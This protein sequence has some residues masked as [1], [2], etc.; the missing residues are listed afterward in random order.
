MIGILPVALR[1]SA[2]LTHLFMQLQLS[3]EPD[4]IEMRLDISVLSAKQQG[5]DP[6]IIV[7]DLGK[8]AATKAIL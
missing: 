1:F 8:L 2:G 6:K 7:L 3:C 5:V 4:L